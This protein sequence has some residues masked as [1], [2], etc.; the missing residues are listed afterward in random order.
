MKKREKEAG[1]DGKGDIERYL[2]REGR[3]GGVDR[4]VG[5]I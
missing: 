4:I 2:G 5:K 3:K 1:R